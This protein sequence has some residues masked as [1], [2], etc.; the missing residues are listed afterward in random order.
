MLKQLNARKLDDA[1]QDD[2]VLNFDLKEHTFSCLMPDRIKELTIGALEL[3]NLKRI[4]K[5]TIAKDTYAVS[6]DKGRALNFNVSVYQSRKSKLAKIYC[7]CSTCAILPYICPIR[8]AIA[9]LEKKPE[10]ISNHFEK[11]ARATPKSSKKK[12]S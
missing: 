12:R 2:L 3:I 7:K 1:K 5:L 6:D 4:E 10:L 9:H 11:Q 8:V